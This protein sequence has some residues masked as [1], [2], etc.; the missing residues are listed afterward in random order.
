MKSVI[1]TISGTRG[2][3]L[4]PKYEDK[5]EA[6]HQARWRKCNSGIVNLALDAWKDRERDDCVASGKL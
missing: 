6:L 3:I 4:D 5:H 2:S 1:V